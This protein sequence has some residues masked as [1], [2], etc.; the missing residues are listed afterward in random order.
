MYAQTVASKQHRATYR[1][2]STKKSGADESLFANSASGSMRDVAVLSSSQMKSIQ[3]LVGSTLDQ[4]VLST[5]ELQRMKDTASGEIERRAAAAR[6]A[7]ASAKADGF[8]K[9]KARK[10]RMAELEMQRKA[11]VPLSDIEQAKA[12]AKVATLTSAEMQLSEELDD[13]KKMNQ[14]MLYAKVVTIRDAQCTEKKV[15]EKERQEEERRLDTIMEIE[16]LKALQMYAEREKKQMQD[17]RLGA[18]VITDQIREREKERVRQLEMQDQERDAM[19]RQ[20]GVMKGNE[21]KAAQAKVETGKKMLAEVAM[22]NAQQ[23]ELKKSAGDYEKEDDRRIAAYVRNRELRELEYAHQ[24]E[25]IKAAK[26]RE[27]LR[28]RAMQEKMADKQAELDGLRSKRAIEEAER[29]WRRKEAAAAERQLSINIT[30]NEAR[31]A[32]KLEKERRLMEQAVQ[33]KEEFGR[34]L[35]VQKETTQAEESIKQARVDTLKMHQEELTTQIL[36]NGEVRKKNRMDFLNEG[37]RARQQ[38]EADRL[39][40]EAIKS[41]KLGS[42]HSQ[43]V[44]EKYTVDLSNKK[45]S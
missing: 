6:N 33:E 29:Q 39:K 35:R 38:M 4:S 7:A 11:E 34:I 3:G 18:S 30:L 37:S 36:M 14:M 5:V 43:G 22:S 9:A 12:A 26:E 8:E 31:E 25:G 21:I 17:R 42:L 2:G 40:L 15:I 16:R 20:V 27:T 44:P 41:H 13:V 19:V 10:Q 23:I 24:Q 1:A 28:L 32:Q 45:F